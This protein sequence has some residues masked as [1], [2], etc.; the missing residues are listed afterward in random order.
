MSFPLLRNGDLVTITG[1]VSSVHGKMEK[2]TLSDIHELKIV[3]PCLSIDDIVVYENFGPDICKR[4]KMGN[5]S[6]VCING[7]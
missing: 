4:G 7:I 3:Q 6:Q 1:V 5:V 2:I